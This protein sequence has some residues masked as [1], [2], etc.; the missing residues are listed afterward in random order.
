MQN[1]S[2]N[3]NDARSINRKTALNISLRRQQ[4]MKR[5]M[6]LTS[7]KVPRVSAKSPSSSTNSPSEDK[8][9]STAKGAAIEN[10]N[11]SN[12]SAQPHAFN[13]HIITKISYLVAFLWFWI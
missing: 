13:I 7:T 10:D 11:D 1:T 8:I 5:K 12:T 4:R 6:Y 2:A 3:N 9:S